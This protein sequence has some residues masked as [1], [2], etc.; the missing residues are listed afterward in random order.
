[1]TCFCNVLCYMGYKLVIKGLH[2]LVLV[3]KIEKFFI[4]FSESKY[5]RQS[6]PKKS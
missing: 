1:M 5:P 3:K 6:F 2:S 4:A